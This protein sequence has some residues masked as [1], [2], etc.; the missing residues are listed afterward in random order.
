MNV[1]QSEGKQNKPV[2]VRCRLNYP[3]E[4]TFIRKYASNVSKTGIFAKTR[5]PRSVGEQIHFEF[6]LADG[7][8]L[9]RGVG[10]VAWTRLE[11]PGGPA[12]GMGIKF[13]KLDR[14]GKSLLD[15]VLAYKENP[16]E[17]KDMSRDSQPEAMTEEEYHG[18]EHPVEPAQPGADMNDHVRKTFSKIDLD[19]IDSMLDQI[20]KEP[21]SKKRRVHKKRTSVVPQAPTAVTQPQSSEQVA[22][23][24]VSEPE[25]VLVDESDSN[26]APLDGPIETLTSSLEPAAE[27]TLQ[28]TAAEIE[29][30]PEKADEGTDASN[31]STQDEVDLDSADI[32]EEDDVPQADDDAVNP[33]DRDDDSDDSVMDLGPENET[34]QDVE[35]ARKVSVNSVLPGPPSR[36]SAFSSIP[37]LSLS[38]APP[39][40]ASPAQ[41]KITV[42]AAA[43][44][45]PGPAQLKPVVD[46]VPPPRLDPRAPIYGSYPQINPR[47]PIYDSPA[48][49]NSPVDEL[50][51]PTRDKENF[52]SYPPSTTYPKIDPRA[53]IYSSYPPPAAS[54]SIAPPPTYPRS[55]LSTAPPPIFPSSVPPSGVSKSDVSSVPPVTSSM[56]PS[57]S[58]VPSVSP[59]VYPSPSSV[60][61]LRT[62]QVPMLAMAQDE[63]H[64]ILGE[65][66]IMDAEASTDII[67]E[68]ELDALLNALEDTEAPLEM[69]DIEEISDMDDLE[70]I[71][72]E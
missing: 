21:V 69:D 71:E 3:D 15:R 13:S 35:L 23:A 45:L 19:A 66:S 48:T 44:D 6:S 17:P 29:D 27:L 49:V 38:S 68:D 55:L 32:I 59:S 56:Y 12:P 54:P 67:K 24:S 36:T 57:P 9:L 31:E 33:S 2:S 22:P 62:S 60:P 52:T 14:K 65:P 28:A 46:S 26:E 43:P 5:N 40:A 51:Y 37:P 20:A 70:V 39:P 47:A 63:L 41:L 4:E 10:R 34:F 72:V 42:P 30:E 16:Q 58:Q 25:P 11:S 53:P 7:T 50:S 8:E 18:R 61:P 1:S 64:G